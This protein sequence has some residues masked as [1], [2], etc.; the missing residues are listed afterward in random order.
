[1]LRL[2]FKCK[3]LPANREWWI[4][5]PESLHDLVKCLRK[6]HKNTRPPALHT[7]HVTSHDPVMTSHD[8]CTHLYHTVCKQCWSCLPLPFQLGRAYERKQ[9]DSCAGLAMDA[10]EHLCVCA[11]VRKHIRNSIITIHSQV[12]NKVWRGEQVEL[13]IRYRTP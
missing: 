3:P 7:G 4:E 12:Y 9:T 6:E 13:V 5:F 10:L 11:C 8:S 1:M 2:H